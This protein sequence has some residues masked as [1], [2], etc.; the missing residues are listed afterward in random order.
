MQEIFCY[1]KVS[2]FYF[3]SGIPPG[4]PGSH[5]SCLEPSPL[6]QEPPPGLQEAPPKAQEVDFFTREGKKPLQEADYFKQ[7]GLPCFQE[8]NIFL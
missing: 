8:S 6:V 5:I 1:W 7:E 2:F 3:H 4:S